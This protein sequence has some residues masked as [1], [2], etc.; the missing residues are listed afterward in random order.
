M[1][2]NIRKYAIGA[3]FVASSL[4][5]GSALA[6][7]KTDENGLTPK[8]WM[9]FDARNYDNVGSSTMT[10]TGYSWNGDWFSGADANRWALGNT[11]RWG[12]FDETPVRPF[13]L[14][15]TVKL[16]QNETDRT[17]EWQDGNRVMFAMGRIG[18]DVIGF[19]N[20]PDFGLRAFYNNSA[21]QT[22]Q[23]EAKEVGKG[24]VTAALVA[25]ADSDEVDVYIAGEKVDTVEWHLTS[26]NNELQTGAPCGGERDKA[27]TAYYEQLDDIR[28]YDIALTDEQV[29]TIHEATYALA[30]DENG[31]QPVHWMTFDEGGDAWAQHGLKRIN[32]SG[33][34]VSIVDSPTGGKALN[35]TDSPWCN[36]LVKMEGDFTWV[37][38]VKAKNQD[39]NHRVVWSRGQAYEKSIGLYTFGSKVGIFAYQYTA[40]KDPG[41][42][43]EGGNA[44]YFCETELSEASGVYTSVA[45]VFKKGQDGAL[46]RFELY[47]NGKKIAEE[48]T[49]LDPEFS[50][51]NYGDGLQ[52]GTGYRSGIPGI[53]TAGGSIDDF[54][55]YDQALTAAQLAKIATPWAALMDELGE[56]PRHWYKF[57]GSSESNGLS[58]MNFDG[59]TWGYVSAVDG[60]ALKVTS[61]PWGAGA[62]Q[63]TGAFTY[64]TAVNT[65]TATTEEPR[66]I[67]ARGAAD[68]KS[69]ILAQ[70]NG[71]KIGLCTVERT[72]GQIET[73]AWNDPT[74]HGPRTLL[75]SDVIEDAM[76]AYHS[77]AVVYEPST[78]EGENGLFTLYI[79]G[80]GVE[81]VESPVSPAEITNGRFQFG[82][83]H[84]SGISG[85]HTCGAD[86]DD[87]RY[88][89]RALTEG[90]IYKIAKTFTS[91]LILP[92]FTF[93]CYPGGG[94]PQGW[95]TQWDYDHFT[96]N[97][98]YL[99]AGS[100]PYAYEIVHVY[101]ETQHHPG[102][103]LE[104]TARRSFAIYANI[105][106]VSSTDERTHVM[107]GLGSSL[108]NQF[109]GIVRVGNEVKLCYRRE[110]ALVYSEQSV[111]VEGLLGYHTYVLT[112]DVETGATLWFDGQKVIEDTR[113]V[114]KVKPDNG[115][116][117]G[118]A[119]SGEY[120]GLYSANG[121]A[122]SNVVGYNEVIGEPEIAKLV[123]TYPRT[124]TV[125]AIPDPNAAS[126]RMKTLSMSM[127]RGG[128]Y[129]NYLGLTRGTLIVPEGVTTQV[130]YV[131][132]LNTGSADNYCD[133][134]INGRLVTTSP[135]TGW[136]KDV[137]DDRTG[138]LFGHWSG[139][140]LYTIR[141]E[142]DASVSYIEAAYSASNQLIRVDGGVVKA[143]GIWYANA[144]YRPVST[145]E[146]ELLN[147]GRVELTDGNVGLAIE[148]FVKGEGG[149]L[150][151]GTSMP[152]SKLVT[153]EGGASL[154][155]DIPEGR[156]VTFSQQPTGS[157]S[158]VLDKVGTFVTLPAR[159][160]NGV[161]VRSGLKGYV[162]R[163]TTNADGTV[164]Y[165]LGKI[166]SMIIR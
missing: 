28:L 55:Y 85:T 3:A 90:E 37:T 154:T 101:G 88:Y 50:T 130:P 113:D 40:P 81:Q 125:A 44:V 131:R 108:N 159:A 41:W 69:L 115:F 48:E 105:E 25:K 51:G 126:N 80:E 84:G 63:M 6:D 152:V 142:L 71:T 118:I 121:M 104:N 58:S 124:T 64:V 122:L 155:L 73:S 86:V 87:F 7:A 97:R 117:L 153:F 158:I 18:Q 102:K 134:E 148:T 116:Q 17:F 45:I 53:A 30:R 70:Y 34:G 57:N 29:K 150:K 93:D 132:T 14:L 166:F 137:Y 140:G 138:V 33:G 46:N 106:R 2:M 59:G 79:D 146:L 54:R 23:S 128:G 147:G 160:A 100:H 65:K 143:K 27:Y 16:P 111:N 61:G 68:N 103:G 56:L 72:S 96:D 135:V 157:G 49:E 77:V 78:N 141:G 35:P 76:E 26:L 139:S 24:F 11:S 145:T 82:N 123:E 89:D 110:N 66:I 91:G 8:Y 1:N 21:N 47:A 92:K 75:K 136:G 133:M 36:Q 98:V 31:L 99:G 94:A 12:N 95:F 13:T 43:E 107:M 19:S 60:S 9:D 67:W 109:M 83:G 62:Q 5:A 162:A 127:E 129:G 144:S 120:N 165:T 164:T 42:G 15:I 22:V 163:A 112:Y 114:A 161:R 151:V 38:A 119:W 20:T 149:T 74:T 156:T 52:F 39:T 32:K 4:L 10:F